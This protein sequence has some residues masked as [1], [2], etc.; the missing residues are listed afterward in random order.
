[1]NTT[2]T[3]A[4]WKAFSVVA[5]HSVR[6]P[7]SWKCGS[8]SHLVRANADGFATVTAVFRRQYE[9]FLRTVV[10]ALGPAIVAAGL[11]QHHLFS[12]ERGFLL[13]LIKVGPIR[14]QLIAPVLA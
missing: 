5:D 4:S 8:R 7:V 3:I 1:M 10:V 6:C 12:R 13:G 2:V 14:M 11:Q 9:L